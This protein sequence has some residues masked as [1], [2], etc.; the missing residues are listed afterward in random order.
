MIVH[1]TWNL[2][3][4]KVLTGTELTKVSTAKGNSSF[5]QPKAG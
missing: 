5:P 2:S 4:L 3:M 1:V